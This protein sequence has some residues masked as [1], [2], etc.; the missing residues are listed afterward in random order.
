MGRAWLRGWSWLVLAGLVYGLALSGARAQARLEGLSIQTTEQTVLLS[1][2]LFFELPTPVEDALQRG[3]PL[4]FS[5]EAGVYLDRWYWTDKL[6]ARGQRFWR[7]SYQPLTRRYRLQSSQQPIDNSGL[8]VG[9]AQTY[10][11]LPEALSALQ[12]ISTWALPTGAL[13][14]AAR[15]RVEFRFR[16]E[17]SALLRPWLVGSNDG[18]WG[19]S[20][21]HQQ[22]FKV[23]VRP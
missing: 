1:A 2:Q 19:L 20:V 22:T 9:L 10:D 13:D 7:L 16:L 18:E 5:A 3:V 17:P 12:R 14:D 21:Q 15:H 4:F 23:G 11:A 6:L 8:G